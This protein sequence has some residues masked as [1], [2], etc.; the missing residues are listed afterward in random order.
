MTMSLKL[1]V[2]LAGLCTSYFFYYTAFSMIAPFF[3]DEAER[4]SVREGIIGFIFSSYSFTAIVLSSLSGRIIPK[5]GARSGYL[6][7]M[8]GAGFTTLAYGFLDKIDDEKTNLFIVMAS[9]VRIFEAAFCILSI[10]SSVAIIFHQYPRSV[11]GK[12]LGMT[13]MFFGAGLTSG[14][15]LGGI[16][17]DVGGYGLP[18]YVVGAGILLT[19]PFSYWVVDKNIDTDR[20]EASMFKLFKNAPGITIPALVRVVTGIVHAFI[21]PILAL[22]LTSEFLVESKTL[23]G[24]LFSILTVGYGIGSP[25]WGWLGDKQGLLRWSILVGILLVTFPVFLMGPCPW[26]HITPTLWLLGTSL[27]FTG[28]GVAVGVII[29]VDI[30]EKAKSSGM[31]DNMALGAMVSGVYYSAYFIGTATGPI[32]GG[33]LYQMWGFG[34][35]TTAVAFLCLLTCFVYSGFMARESCLERQRAQY[36]DLEKS[37]REMKNVS[38][39][40]KKPLSTS[41]PQY[42][43]D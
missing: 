17:F 38:S 10:N 29:M 25:V 11:Q 43:E 42:T 35:T 13:N 26:F 34:W 18:F 36:S 28:A 41:Y 19:V 2:L 22:Y 20:Q 39:D 3:P 24:L 15:L 7:G 32:V 21:M 37:N 23:Q 33:I 27:F 14:P 31:E 9:V 12:V 6:F 5:I 1:K 16:L 4:H 30:M 40:E 8:F